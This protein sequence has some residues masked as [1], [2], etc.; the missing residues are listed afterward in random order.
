[1]KR[2]PLQ[3]LI[4]KG[5]TSKE[6][7]IIAIERSQTAY[8]FYKEDKM[9]YQALRIFS[10]NQVVYKILEEF[11]LSRQSNLREEI[12]LYI[13]HL[14]DWI[15]NFETTVNLQKPALE[16]HFVFNRLKNSFEFPSHFLNTLK[17]DK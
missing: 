13:F 10:A 15:N 1:M 17:K 9:Y 14:E 11:L 5:M 12:L 3:Q 7:L 8:A 6:K 16:D 2:I 4:L